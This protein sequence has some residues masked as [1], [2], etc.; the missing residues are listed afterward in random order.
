[1]GFKRKDAS[2]TLV[3]EIHIWEKKGK[4]LRVTTLE[5]KSSPSLVSLFPNAPM[6]NCTY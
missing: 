3:S 6:F 1:M 4:C 5:K 2:K